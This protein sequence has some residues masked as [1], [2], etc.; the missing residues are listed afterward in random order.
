MD[1]GF[2]KLGIS[3]PK[4]LPVSTLAWP[5]SD[6]YIKQLMPNSN[7]SKVTGKMENTIPSN[8]FP[9]GKNIVSTERLEK[10]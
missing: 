8:V 3:I 6:T 9:K 2:F 7:S 1:H 4:Y 5:P 10:I